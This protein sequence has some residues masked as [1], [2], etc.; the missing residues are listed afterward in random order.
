MQIAWVHLSEKLEVPKRSKKVIGVDPGVNS[1]LSFY[2]THEEKAY[3]EKLD[4]LF[5]DTL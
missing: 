3:A 2:F 5:Y 4:N 1:S